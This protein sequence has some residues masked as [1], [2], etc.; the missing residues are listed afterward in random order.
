MFQE[1]FVYHIKD[2]YFEKVNDNM[3]MCNKENKQYRPTFLCME[4]PVTPG[5]LWVVPMSTQVKKFAAIRDKQIAKYGKCITIVIGTYDG[6]NAAFLLQNM[7]PI[8]S[9]YLDHI[10]TRNGNPVPVNYSLAKE[11]KRNV[12][13][14]RILIS[15]GKKVVFPDV[16][17]LESLMIEELSVNDK[18]LSFE[19]PS[20]NDRI[21]SIK[22]TQNL[23]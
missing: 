6:K 21:N 18:T 14:L 5:L 2:S 9:Q 7:F 8:T 23:P 22:N 1:R 16:K 20:L 13:Q 17:R 4:D 11:V 3:L 19:N 10:H 15:R 12:Q